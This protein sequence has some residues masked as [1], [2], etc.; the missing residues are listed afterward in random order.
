MLTVKT[1]KRK[2]IKL[3][4]LFIA[5]MLPWL[6]AIVYFNN[7]DGEEIPLRSIKFIKDTIP[8]VDHSKFA[9]LQQEFETPQDL[10]VACLSCHNQTGREVMQTSHWKWTRDYITD[11]G[12]TIQLGKK[13][14]IN[15]F[16][17][18][19]SSN[20]RRCTSCHVGYGWEDNDF[21]FTESKNIDCI[22]CHDRSGTYKKF[23]SG[24]GYPVKEEKKFGKEIYYPPDYKLISQN[25]GPPTNE[26]CGACHFVGGGGNNV[27]HGDIAMEMSNISKTVDVHL[28]VDGAKMG[29][30][31]CHKT[32]RHNI[33]GS[34]YSI[35]STNENRISC[36]QCHS[37]E[38]HIDRTLNFHTRKIACQTCHIPVYAKVS[39]TKMEWDWSTAGKFNEDGSIL[40]KK[41]SAGNIIYHSMKGTF[42]WESDV[43]PEYYW[44][45]GNARH[46]L[47]GDKIDTTEVVQ[48]NSLLGS[49][50][51]RNAKIVPVKVHRSQQI[52]DPL[53]ETMIL[54]HLYGKDSTA[55]W[56]N[57]DWNKAAETGMR[58]VN[59][60]Y[61]GKY[62]FITTEMDWPI[63]H[64]VA[65]IEN[66]L[67][68]ADCHARDSRLQNLTDFYLP[69]RD[70]SSFLD[71]LG[72]GIIIMAFIGVIIHG[73]LR[74]FKNKIF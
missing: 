22:V 23:P 42:S 36:E 63:N 26:N 52:Y 21:D 61:S 15:N 74:I 35:A 27:K 2:F 56:T 50:N 10:T 5:I 18:G 1:S 73:S 57:F 60:P 72:F 11:S 44:F 19:V 41:D 71:L 38:P 67:K 34:L 58:S 24:A 14:I 29:C 66:T 37:E 28:A 12:D 51:D 55:F 3:F 13:N 20:E 43:E 49:Y 33:R 70:Y 64:M 65:P 16:C 9:I 62:A 45:N 68:C 46:Y 8:K 39:A 54:P 7:S 30:V 40:V 69:G 53:N 32:E 6:I 25:I 17:I 31:D 4:S 59:L 47:M 48:L